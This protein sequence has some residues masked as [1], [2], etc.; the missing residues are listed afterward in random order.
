[1][2][3]LASCKCKTEPIQLERHCN[4]RFCPRCSKR[5]IARLKK[6]FNSYLSYYPAD[7]LYSYKFLTI[8]PKNYDDLAFGLKDVRS[9]FRKFIRRKY[10]KERIKG[11]FYIIEGTNRSNGWNL[12]LHVIIFSRRL[13]NVFRGK[14]VHCNQNYLKWDRIKEQF[15]CANKNCR[16]VFE[17]ETPK[18]TLQNEWE[19][20]SKRSCMVDI[21]HIQNKSSVI[22]YCLKYVSSH[23][24]SFDK[25]EDFAFF[26]KTTYGQ[27]LLTSFGEFSGRSAVKGNSFIPYSVFKKQRKKV[28]IC[29]RCN[30]II[31]FQFDLEISRLLDDLNYCSP[32][33]TPPPREVVYA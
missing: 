15:Y 22:N 6:T 13:D 18:S 30:S 17:G 4:K 12:H 3:A 16:H 5:R 31:K 24:E 9:S 10:I 8:K 7:S 23:K 25:I 11:G 19:D 28:C 21:S 32:S 14:C 29:P 27:N 33:S 2:Y 20:S 1:M 26:I